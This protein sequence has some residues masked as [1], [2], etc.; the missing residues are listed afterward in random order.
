M[1]TLKRNH[2]QVLAARA[3]DGKRTRYRIEGV[4]G[5]RLD[6]GVSGSRFWYVRY[7]PGGRNSRRFRYYKIGDATSVSLEKATKR[8]HDILNAVHVEERDPIAERSQRKTDGALCFG[9]LFDEW[10]ARHARPNLARHE[11]DLTYYRCHIK[12]DFAKRSVPEL[13]RVEIARYRDVVARKTSPLVSNEVLMLINRVL[14]WSLDEG[15][16][17]ANPAARLRKVGKKRPRVLSEDEIRTLW[18][19]L[20]HMDALTGDH[21]KRGE[22]GRMLSPA[23]RSSLRLLLLTGQRRGEIAGARKSELELSG[24]N[25]VWTIPGARTKNRILH[26]LPLAPMAAAEFARAVAASPKKSPFVFASADDPLE[27][28]MSADAVTRAMAR[29]TAQIG[30]VGAAPHDLRRTVGT[31]M[32]RLGLPVHVRSL[33]LNHSSQSR[34]VTDAVYNRYAYDPEKR[35]A[36][37]RWEHQLRALVAEKRGVF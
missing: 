30:I 34:S 14:N 31:E 13:K 5:L 11:T 17:D 2:R 8:A 29:L 36:L 37:L 4:P 33:V 24:P 25:P 6:V 35:D 21:L 12:G 3:V 1:P 19:A 15:L 9:D 26:R 20:A 22:S 32:A 18:H 7:Q 28:S 10:Y 27:A 23:T 16:I